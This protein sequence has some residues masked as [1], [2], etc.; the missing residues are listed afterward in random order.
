MHKNHLKQCPKMDQKWTQNGPKMGPKWPPKWTPKWIPSGT[1]FS[2][3]KLA[4]SSLKVRNPRPRTESASLWRVDQKSFT[5]AYSVMRST[6]FVYIR[7]VRYMNACIYLRF[8]CLEFL[9]TPRSSHATFANAVRT[10]FSQ[11]L[12][13]HF[14]IS[15]SHAVFTRWFYVFFVF[16]PYAH[17]LFTFTM[18]DIVFARYVRFPYFRL[19]HI[20]NPRLQSPNFIT[21]MYVFASTAQTS[22]PEH[23]S[24]PRPCVL[25]CATNTPIWH[26]GY[27]SKN[28]AFT[29]SSRRMFRFPTATPTE[30][31][32]AVAEAAESK[33]AFG[34]GSMRWGACSNNLL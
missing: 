11:I 16:P 18:F 7:N 28:W 21:L 10:L 3:L 2:S 6:W 1:P 25:S 12:L 32:G 24:T 19:E 33:Y 26:T 27:S 5:S 13:T 20:S 31:V 15:L 34:W 14:C 17:S 8:L 29:N 22:L 4:I 9:R 23:S 30:T